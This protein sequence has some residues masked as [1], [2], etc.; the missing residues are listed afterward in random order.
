[1]AATLESLFECV[2][3][4]VIQISFRWK[5]YCQLFDSGPDNIT[6]L[7]TSGAE[8]FRL[9]QRLALDDAMLALSRLTDPVYSGR[10]KSDENASIKF[11]LQE[12]TAS[13]DQDTLA[14]LQGSFDRLENHVRD[15]R[16]HRNK[17]L[18]HPDLYHSLQPDA[19]PRVLYDD[20]EGAM[21]EC[22]YLMS[23]LGKSLFARTCSYEVIIPFGRSASDLLSW[24]RK[25]HAQDAAEG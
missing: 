7:N 21:K 6:L 3:D 19:L 17:A 18:A 16:V 8:V 14:Q 24:L 9:F 2:N 23:T 15:V 11:L 22:R 5:I 13:L 20:L 12:A 25:A 10:N 1:M 4:S